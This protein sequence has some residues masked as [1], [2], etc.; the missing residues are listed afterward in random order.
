MFC[1]FEFHLLLIWLHYFYGICTIFICSRTGSRQATPIRRRDRCSMTQE[2]VETNC[3]RLTRP[4][5][6]ILKRRLFHS[7][8]Q[9]PPHN[10]T[11]GFNVE[12]WM[13]C[14]TTIPS[15]F[16]QFCFCFVYKHPRI[17][18]S[19]ESVG[20]GGRGTTCTR[21]EGNKINIPISWVK[22][23]YKRS[24]HSTYKGHSGEASAK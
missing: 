19:T 2:G 11:Q 20:G 5:T 21:G 16:L 24:H 15:F 4:E 12:H 8:E 6:R 22:S 17:W 7:A 14:G 23:V 13:S 10:K 18:L 9:H 1:Y 3:N